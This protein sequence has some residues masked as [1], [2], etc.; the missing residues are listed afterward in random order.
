MQIGTAIE[1]TRQFFEA[2]HVPTRFSD[3][4]LAG[5]DIEQILSL[6]QRHSMVNL[7][8]RS[9]VTLEMMRKILNLSL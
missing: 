2:M 7:G 1:K 8:E 6:S 4:N 3:Y 5:F 9:D